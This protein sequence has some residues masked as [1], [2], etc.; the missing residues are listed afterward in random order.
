M[1]MI[2]IHHTINLVT[3]LDETH[4]VAQRLLNEVPES[5]RPKFLAD[6]FLRLLKE[7]QFIEKLNEGNHYATL[8][9]VA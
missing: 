4:P 2:S 3:E 8:K 5:M 9:V 1:E 7:E 6:L